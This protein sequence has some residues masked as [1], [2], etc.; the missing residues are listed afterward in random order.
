MT[1]LERFNHVQREIGIEGP[2]NMKDTML[3]ARELLGIQVWSDDKAL[4]EQLCDVEDVL[5]LPPPIET[6]QTLPPGSARIRSP[7]T[8]RS[9]LQK[10]ERRMSQAQIS[11]M[12]FSG[13]DTAMFGDGHIESESPSGGM[14][15]IVEESAAT[16]DATT[17]SAPVVQTK[18]SPEVLHI[19][20]RRAQ[21]VQVELVKKEEEEEAEMAAEMEE[22]SYE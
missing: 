17:G 14:D 16:P 7:P 8:H 13:L 5:G 3:Q 12:M 15:I 1:L 22:G 20:A 2:C 18:V 10:S 21:D 11:E 9:Y 4:P 6:I 19:S